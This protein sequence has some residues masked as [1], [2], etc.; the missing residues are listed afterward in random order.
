MRLRRAGGFP[1]KIASQQQRAQFPWHQFEGPLFKLTGVARTS[2]ASARNLGCV[3]C[4][5][6][7]ALGSPKGPNRL[8]KQASPN[9]TLEHWDIRLAWNRL[10]ESIE[11]TASKAV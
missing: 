8:R 7:L 3:R 11:Q 10:I 1:S 2:D 9:M 6:A 4:G 5:L